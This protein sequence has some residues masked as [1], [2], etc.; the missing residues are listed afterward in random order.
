MKILNNLVSAY[1]DLAEINAIEHKTMYMSDY[2]EH[3]DRILSS[4]GKEVL[5][6]AGS[7]S[8]KQT[9]EK[10]EAEYQKFIQKNLSPVEKTAKDAE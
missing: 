7:I 3:L 2:V 5:D 4:T 6:N 1:F 8:H 10:A 9:M